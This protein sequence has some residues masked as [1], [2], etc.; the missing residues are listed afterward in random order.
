M[1]NGD[2]AYYQS[3]HYTVVPKDVKN[4]GCKIVPNESNERIHIDHDD[5]KINEESVITT[6]EI[7]EVQQLLETPSKLTAESSSDYDEMVKLLPM[8]IKTLEESDKLEDMKRF[9]QLLADEKFPMQNIAYE[10]FN[11]LIRW[12]SV[13]KCN[14]MRYSPVTLRFWRSGRHM[15]KKKYIRTMSGPKLSGCSTTHEDERGKYS[16]EHSKVNFAVPSDRLLRPNKQIKQECQSPGMLY[17]TL[18]KIA[19]QNKDNEN[20]YKLAIDLK[21]LDWGGKD[22]DIDCWGIETPNLGERK[23]VLEQDHEVI[24]K[25]EMIIQIR[26]QGLET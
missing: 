11:D 24:N 18:D 25:L 20:S 3:R 7:K 26:P 22:G 17:S 13:E 2:K 5:N 16:T 10:L 19:E 1:K 6:E 14:L 12:L 23:I 8:V 15:L 4:R 21:L 9:L